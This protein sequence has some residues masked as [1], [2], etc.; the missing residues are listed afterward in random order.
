MRSSNA[1]LAAIYTC[2][3]TPMQDPALWSLNND[4]TSDWDEQ[5]V[6][7]SAQSLTESILEH[8]Y[9]NGR[10][11]HRMSKEQYQLPTDETKQDRLDM[12]HR[13]KPDVVYDSTFYTHCGHDRF[14]SRAIGFDGERPADEVET[15]VAR[16]DWFG[17]WE[18]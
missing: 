13:E 3:L 16:K 8:V 15:G 10:R 5:S 14:A 9:E 7:S 4:T 18:W 11:Y 6:A 2:G 17:G 1:I 12:V